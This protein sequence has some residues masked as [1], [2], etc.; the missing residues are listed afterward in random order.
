MSNISLYTRTRNLSRRELVI[1]VKTVLNLLHK[2]YHKPY[3]KK[4]KFKVYRYKAPKRK[5]GVYVLRRNTKHYKGVADWTKED[6]LITIHLKRNKTIK[7][8][9]ISLLHEYCHYTQDMKIYFEFWKEYGY[10]KNPY[11]LQ[12]ENFARTNAVRA[13]SECKWVF[14]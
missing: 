11:E 13:F 3:H 14:E 1:Y 6:N 9:T 5:P 10:W 4:I 2:E 12:A 8:L 7:S